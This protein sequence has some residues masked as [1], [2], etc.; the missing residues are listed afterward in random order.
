MINDFL[1][2][3]QLAK[4]KIVHETLK[5]ILGEDDVATGRY[6]KETQ[7]FNIRPSAPVIF[8]AG[9]KARQIKIMQRKRAQSR[10]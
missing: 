5:I 3:A 7:Q 6:L 4:D 2:Q 9:I 8:K 10:D 1:D